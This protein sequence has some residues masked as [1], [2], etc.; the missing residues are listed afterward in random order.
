[1]RN[2]A[3][4]WYREGMSVAEARDLAA[5][6]A[7]VAERR[8]TRFFLA[9]RDGE[10]G[11]YC[12]LLGEDGI[13]EV[14]SVYTSER[15]RGAGLASAVVRAAIAGSRERGD[16]LITIAADAADWPQRLYERLGFETIDTRLS[17]TRKPS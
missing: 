17:F 2:L 8:P 3:E 12:M 15:H 9:E 14:E 16:D 4:Q 1:M 11:G 6:D 5:A 13:G 10:P 7:D